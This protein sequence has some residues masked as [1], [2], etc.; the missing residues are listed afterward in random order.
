MK[1]SKFKLGDR[2]VLV[3]RSPIMTVTK[4]NKT[5]DGRLLVTATWYR[6]SQDDFGEMKAPEEAF[7]L[8]E[9]GDEP[10]Y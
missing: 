6:T 5:T 9:K 7:R 4:M 2:V 3:S 1:E 10:A 8:A